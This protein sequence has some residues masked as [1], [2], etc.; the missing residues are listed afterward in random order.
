MPS[1]V[2]TLL[3]NRLIWGGIAVAALALASWRFRFVTVARHRR[4]PQATAPAPAPVIGQSAPTRPVFGAGVYFA[5]FRSQV[6]MD[7]RGVFKSY[8]F[9]VLL[10]FALMNVVNGF[11]LATSQLFGTPLIPVTRVMLELI[12]GMYGFMT[13]IILVY[14]AGELVH[15]ERQSHVSD[16]VDA[17]PFANGIVVAGKIV[18]LWLIVAAVQLMG[19]F[20]AMVAQLL[21]GYSNFEIPTY[22]FGLFIVQ[23]AFPF[24]LCVVAIAVQSLVDNKFV[25]MLAIVVLF[26]VMGALDSLGF[27]HVLYQLGIPAAPLSDMNGW[28]HFLEPIFTVGAYWALIMVLVGSLAHLFMRRGT[29]GGYRERF[30]EARRRFTLPL[31]TVATVALLGAAIV[32]G[33]IFYNTNVLN[34][35]LTAD[36]LEAMQADYEK[37]YKRYET[38]PMP[39]PVSVDVEV[40]IF[41]GE[42][43]S[44]AAAAC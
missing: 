27:E 42:R 33:W 22:L 23:G 36:D 31:A 38:L 8:P 11:V 21:N 28:G 18:A 30:I 43:A 16:Y 3:T 37:S 40:D 44:K 10:L 34:T 20:A 41:P 35:Y 2:G 19:M 14:Y 29:V 7:L 15:R 4:A 12:Q 24:L 39:E 26:F 25:G 5:Q 32:G 17:M 9:Y 13:V 6:L 1:F